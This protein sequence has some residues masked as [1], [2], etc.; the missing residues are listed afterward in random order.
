MG[1]AH[2]SNLSTFFVRRLYAKG[3]L[4]IAAAQ[5]AASTAGETVHAS[6]GSYDD[7][8]MIRMGLGDVIGFLSN[9]NPNLPPRMR[10]PVIEPV[11]LTPE[12]AKV[13]AEFQSPGCLE[14]SGGDDGNGGEYGVFD[15]I[16]WKFAK[17]W[18]AEYPDG[19]PVL[20]SVTH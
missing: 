20:G 9:A 3:R 2:L 7:P 8:C 10:T 17:G 13:L 14:W 12:Q 19:I 16:E 4:T 11:S 15:S 1:H 18:R 6:E 5:E